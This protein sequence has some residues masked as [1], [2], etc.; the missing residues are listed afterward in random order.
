MLFGRP[1]TTG[2]AGFGINHDALAFNQPLL[3][4]RHQ[5]QQA[6]SGETTRGAHQLGLSEG[7]ASPLHQAINSLL[8]EGIVLALL[9]GGFLAVS[10]RPLAQ[11][12]EA[13]IR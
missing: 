7:I 10:R 1:A 4:Q 3:Q 8:A 5:S 2:G 11:A 13:V 6:R 9:R 12:G